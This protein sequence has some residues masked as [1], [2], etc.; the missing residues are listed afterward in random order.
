MLT[1]SLRISIASAVIALG[2]PMCCVAASNI[3]QVNANGKSCLHKKVP[4]Y[5]TIQEAVNAVASGG[6]V[7][8]CPGSYPEQV[9]ITQP[10]TLR[11]VQSGNRDAAVVIPPATGLK[12][13]QGTFTAPQVFVN[14]ITAGP[15]TIENLTVDASHN[16][17]GCGTLFEGV[18][19]RDASGSVNH[20]ATRNQ[21][22]TVGGKDCN[23]GF[24]IRVNGGT[25]VSV[26]VENSSARSYDQ[27]GILAQLAFATITIKNNS[28][29]GP[30]PIKDVA[31]IGIWM[32][33]G[34]TGLVSRNS[35]VNN[36]G[37]SAGGSAGILVQGTH[38]AQITGNTLGN[39]AY[40]IKFIPNP[41]FDADNGSATQNTMLGSRIDGI[42]LCS[43]NNM[44]QGN[45]I[46]ASAESGVNLACGA[47]N[48]T[49]TKNTV[50]EACA[51]ILVDPSVSGN[52]TTPNSIF[53]ATTVQL[54]GRSCS[55]A[56]Q[57]RGNDR[58]GP[59]L[60]QSGSRVPFPD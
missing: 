13:L 14:S 44:V 23:T 28:V 29:S 40:G 27:V 3:V 15:V 35:I 57:R 37:L 55:A 42:Y 45:T 9:T 18:Y 16:L 54:T 10:L 8:V 11:G 24:G 30:G 48:N 2:L 36:S 26:V 21:I 33:D 49:V 17:L 25:N 43:N 12:V 20:V 34:A 5:T 53:N 58:K 6:T 52:V 46:S 31:T 41:N 56:G 1:P 4:V 39:N 32:L 38:G 50:N 60:K 47:N 22:A 51:G 59:V 19:F 7:L